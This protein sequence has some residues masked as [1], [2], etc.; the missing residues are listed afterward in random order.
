MS[1]LIYMAILPAI[2]AGALYLAVVVAAGWV[3]YRCFGYIPKGYEERLQS[4]GLKSTETAVNLANLP[5]VVPRGTSNLRTGGELPA[6]LGNGTRPQLNTII[7]FSALLRQHVTRQFAPSEVAEYARQ[8]NI[9]ATQL[10]GELDEV[11]AQGAS[12]S[13]REKPEPLP[14]EKSSKRGLRA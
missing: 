6:A 5:Q 4:G 11:V 9:A 13:D 12:S 3:G 10:L 2:A 14:D 1:D 8:I 7:G